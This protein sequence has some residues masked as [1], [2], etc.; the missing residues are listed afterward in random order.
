[1]RLTTWNILHGRSLED[2]QVDAQR[3]RDA[4]VEIDADV[5]GLQEVDR[6]QPRSA[7]RDQTAQ[8][9]TAVG[10]RDWRFV[11]ALIGTPGMRW[12]PAGE[13]DAQQT[14]AYGV[15]LVSRYPVTSWHEL[16]MAAAPVR[17]PVLEP[18]RRRLTW[19]ADEPRVAVAAV[20][21]APLGELTVATTHLSFVPGQNLWQLRRVA[22]WLR[23]LP[24]PQVLLGDL[25]Q[26]V[27]LHGARSG[28]RS[29]ARA[30]THP[31]DRPRRQLDHILAR[32]ALP[33]STSTQTLAL[34]ISDHRALSVQ[35]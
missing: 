31:A 8:I 13:A 1:M 15:A 5:L 9:A 3:L 33:P 2:D 35:W 10:A 7:G 14:P 21:G 34:P 17:G 12:R 27:L 18:G 19:L 22:R 26:R 11:P 20:L 6:G 28:F 29:L 25:N 23:R 30:P 16:R 32:G 4:V 24:G